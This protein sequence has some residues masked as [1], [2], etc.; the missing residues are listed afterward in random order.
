MNPGFCVETM[1]A[2]CTIRGTVLDTVQIILNPVD[3]LA[4]PFQ[5]CC[6]HGFLRAQYKKKE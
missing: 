3:T 5:F 6:V 4:P 1:A 2:T